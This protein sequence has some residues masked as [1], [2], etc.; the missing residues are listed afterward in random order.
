MF[1]FPTTTAVGSGKSVVYNWLSALAVAPS[2][3]QPDARSVSIA[4]RMLGVRNSGKRPTAPREARMQFF[5]KRVRPRHHSIEQQIHPAASAVRNVMP[6]LSGF[7]IFSAMSN[8]HL[9]LKRKLRL[10]SAERKLG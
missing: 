8:R 10:P 3:H 2:T 9:G 6:R 1:S 7:A 4:S 5:V